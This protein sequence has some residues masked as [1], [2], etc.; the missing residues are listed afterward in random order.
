MDITLVAAAHSNEVHGIS[1]QDKK[2]GCGINLFKGENVTVYRRLGPMKDLKEV[3]CEKC[4]ANLVKKMIK[5]DK[6]EMTRL[7]KEEKQRAKMGMEDEGIVPLGNTT[8]KI[9]RSPEQIRQDELRQQEL[10][11]AAQM[12]QQ[13]QAPV[14]PQPQPQYQNPAFAQQNNAPQSNA[15][16]GKVVPQGSVPEGNYASSE[17]VAQPQQPRQ[18]RS[19]QPDFVKNIQSS[20]KRPGSIQPRQPQ[21][22]AAPVVQPME[23]PSAPQPMAQPVQSSAP[24]GYVPPSAQQGYVPPFQ[25]APVQPMEQPSAAPQPVQQPAVQKT[26]PGTGIVMDAGLAAFAIDKP[27]EETADD[28]LSQFSVEEKPAETNDFLGQFSVN[29]AENL[30]QEE[31]TFEDSFEDTSTPV[32]DNVDDILSMFAVGN[33]SPAPA[34]K[35]VET[36]VLDDIAPVQP[37]A[38]PVL[39]AVAPVLDDIAPV[40]TETPVLDAVAP[41]L[42]YIAPVQTETPVLDAAAPVLD[43]I[44]PVQT[45]VPVLDEVQPVETPSFDDFTSDTAEEPAAEETA[46]PVAE[47]TPVLNEFDAVPQELPEVPVIEENKPVQPAAPQQTAPQPA[48]VQPQIVFVPQQTGVDQNGQPIFTNIQMKFMG[49]DQ[50]GQPI[51]ATMDGKPVRR[52]AVPPMQNMSLDPP[53][54]NVS[55]IAVNPHTRQTSQAFINAIASSKDYAD[56]NLIETQGLKVNAPF[57]SSIE[58]ALS[59]MGDDT[60]KKR[61]LEEQRRKQQEIVPEVNEYR[62]PSR[63][64]MRNA[65]APSPMRPAGPIQEQKDPRFM[66]KDELKAYK[67]AEKINQKFKKDLA[68]RGL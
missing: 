7:I 14:Q 24:Q 8:A 63:G 46:E 3:T 2:T 1:E 35:P 67:K 13:A 65:A 30:T 19:P 52:M 57:V 33:T 47:E 12:Q 43:D 60:A 56:K 58:D 23:Q 48:P 53:T 18:N 55:K 29:A 32:L 26:I 66:T 5:A 59:T 15:M 45:E 10:R 68:K 28:F 22:Q 31:E 50:N 17:R 51:L 11:M 54:A 20:I 4:K 36:P 41:V 21:Q 38:A 27:V 62:G 16:G 25:Q 6:K 9:T 39:D 37:V 40:Q 49:I 44:A 34:P 64:L 61:M 42:D